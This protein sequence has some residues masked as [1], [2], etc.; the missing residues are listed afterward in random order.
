MNKIFFLMLMSCMLIIFL[1]T[2][3]K[4]HPI[5][6]TISL[7]LYSSLIC[8]IMSLW[9]FNFLYSIMTFLMLISGLL[10]IF[11]YFSSLIA[12]E[13]NKITINFYIMLSLI[14]NYL[15]MMMNIMFNNFNF[16]SMPYNFWESMNIFYNLNSVQFNNML[17]IY[18]YPYMNVTI[19]CILYLLM[20]LFIIIKISSIKFGSLRKIK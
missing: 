10:I 18:N 5:F 13:K 1:L 20:S 9:S 12:N 19:M 2:I 16:F 6:L 11:M 4:I 7:L 3:M 15:T 8:I 14:L 17:M